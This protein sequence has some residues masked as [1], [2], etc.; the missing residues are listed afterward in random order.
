[1]NEKHGSNGFLIGLL[2]G[3]AVGALIGTKKGRQILKDAAEYGIEYVGSTINLKDIESILDQDEEEMM[4]GEINS[5]PKEKVM[6]EQGM[7]E[8][9]SHQEPPKRRLFRGLRKK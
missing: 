8:V 7:S 2:I 5:E 9:G 3:G 6:A 1:M 4:Q